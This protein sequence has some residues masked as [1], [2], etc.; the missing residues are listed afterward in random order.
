MMWPKE[1]YQNSLVP[2]MMAGAQE[3]GDNPGL[4][5]RESQL[6]EPS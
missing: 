3:E 4:I 6:C 2:P 5:P 1:H